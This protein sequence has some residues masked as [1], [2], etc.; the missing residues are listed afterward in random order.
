M[1]EPEVTNTGQA[2]KKGK[3][4]NI[5][6]ETRKEIIERVVN[7]KQSLRQVQILTIYEVSQGLCIN[8]STC[9]DILHKFRT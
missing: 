3:Y 8:Y 4:Q 2:R 9:R 6:L 1:L 5:P 7:L